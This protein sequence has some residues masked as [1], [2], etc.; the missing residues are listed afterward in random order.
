MNRAAHWSALQRK[1]KYIAARKAKLSDAWFHFDVLHEPKL[2]ATQKTFEDF[3][4]KNDRARRPWLF[5]P[6]LK[7]QKGGKGRG[8]HAPH[9]GR[10]GHVGGSSPRGST[11]A[12]SWDVSD[13]T[14]GE[15]L[16][17]ISKQGLEKALSIPGTGLKLNVREEGGNLLVDSVWSDPDGKKE[18]GIGVRHVTK[19]PDGKRHWHL[20]EQM[21]WQDF[22]NKGLAGDLFEREKALARKAGCA[23]IELT[24]DLSIG[25]Y[26]WAKKGFEYKDK[27]Q[28]AR[29][30]RQFKAWV[31]AKG[32]KLTK[33]EFPTFKSA[34][35]VAEFDLRVKWRGTVTSVFLERFDIRNPDVPAGMK[36]PLGKAF[37]LDMGEGGHGPWE[38]VLGL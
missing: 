1:P 36:L 15:Y 18:V 11:V 5:V 2:P 33:E 38:G 10:P 12:S 8:Y 23:D 9:V 27:R 34:K 20:T 17:G 14:L 13:E 35:E 37:M 22:Q 21:F 16:P 3:L 31:K 4:L 30:T 7:V 32:L 28:A 25:P 26:A 24:A 19:T 29:M 6:V